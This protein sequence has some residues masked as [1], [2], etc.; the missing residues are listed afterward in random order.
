MTTTM[1]TTG[2]E[3]VAWDLSELYAGA[4]DPTLERDLEGTRA[5]VSTYADRYRGKLASLD[6]G[7]LAKAVRELEEIEA[8]RT[9]IGSFAHML[10][11]IDTADPGR[12]ALLQRVQ[13]WDAALETELLFFRL[14]WTALSDDE[15]DALLAS[16]ELS[17]WEHFL[18]A[19][20]RYRPHLLS[21]PEERILAEKSLSSRTAW[22]RLF[23]ELVSAIRVEVEGGD[24][25]LDEA[26]ARLEAPDRDVRRRAAEAISVSLAPGLRT[27]G[28]IFN[29]I[30]L[31]KAIDDRLRSYPHWIASRNLDNEISDEVVGALVDS[32]VGRYDI[33]QRYYRLKA[34]LLGVDRLAHYDRMA[35]VSRNGR[36]VPW[37]EAREVVLDAY[38]S[39]TPDAGRIVSDFFER[40]WI[41]APPRPG[42]TGGAY[43]MTRVPGVHP[44]V[45]MNYTGDR[46]SV[47]TLAHELGHGLHGALAA[48]AGV[49]NSATPLTLAETAS[50]FGEALTFRALREREGDDAQR[51]DLLIGR[52]DD[53]V[54][55]VFRQVALNRFEHAVHTARRG[56]GELSVDSLSGLWLETQG[57]LLGDAVDL[58]GYESWWSYVWHFAL[59]PGYVYA[60]A[61]GYLFSLA[62]FRRYEREGDA[63]VEPYLDLLRAG[64]SRAPEELAASVGLDLTTPELWSEGLEAID[65]L[66]GEAEELAA[67]AGDG[68]RD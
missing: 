67:A 65:E 55:T 40:S 26:L 57:A 15:A 49:F 44:Y 18:R 23:E 66:L 59:Y 46:R 53:A 5:L 39:F 14:E 9:R 16:A 38:S 13:E 3:D 47:L 33:A 34:R 52:L 63:M 22:M 1:T 20:R 19:A 36:V 43:C 32:V 58:R 45:L 24:V 8:T 56:E 21:E 62:I 54:A 64:G 50:V 30:L 27:R 12:G 31:D 48:D 6:A 10:F 35:P 17:H 51:L 4:D 29:T 60:Y 7:E 68:E 2:A 37:D 42:K 11:S 25:S 41:D 28:S 61:F